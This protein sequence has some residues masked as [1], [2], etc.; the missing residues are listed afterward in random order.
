MLLT[1]E[2]A[3][4]KSLSGVTREDDDESTREWLLVALL[5]EARTVEDMVDELAEQS[6]DGVGAAQLERIKARLL[7]AL[8][9]MKHEGMADK[10]TTKRGSPW[11]LTGVT[12]P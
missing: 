4:G 11:M 10:Q 1:F 5:R 9:R 6:R 12:Q 3:D 8:G 7:Q 2:Y